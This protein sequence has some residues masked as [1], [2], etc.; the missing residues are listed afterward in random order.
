MATVTL[1]QPQ[2]MDAF[3][4]FF[5]TVIVATPSQ[6]SITDGLHRQDLFGSFYLSPSGQPGGTITST[7]GY[8]AEVIQY[9]VELNRFAVVVAAS[10]FGGAFRCN[11]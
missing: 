3:P 1:Y 9:S 7:N 5:G 11:W 8:T 2:S 4:I 10:P 6:I